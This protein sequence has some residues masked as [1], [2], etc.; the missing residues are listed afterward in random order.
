MTIQELKAD[1]HNLIDKINEES[2]L[3]AIRTILSKQ[4]EA[5][6]DWAGDL[7]ENLRSELEESISEADEGK[8]ISHKEAMN[9]IKSRYNL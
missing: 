9:R 6:K 5:S 1:L 3:N 4:N 2:I 8:V 7:S